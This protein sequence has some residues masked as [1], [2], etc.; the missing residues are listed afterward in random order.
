[1]GFR[2]L[3]THQDDS[4]TFQRLSAGWSF[5]AYAAGTVVGTISLRGPDSANDC[6]WYRDSQVFSFGQFGVLPER[7]RCGIGRLLIDFVERRAAAEGA[8]ELALDTAEGAVDLIRWYRRLGYRQVDLV[9]W[10]DTN[11]R[12][13]VLSKALPLHASR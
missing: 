3:A 6:A 5:L 13:V 9:S 4:V 8:L 12:S 11:Y 1:M 10:H 2:Y 7:Q